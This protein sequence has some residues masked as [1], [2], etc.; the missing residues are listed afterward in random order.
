MSIYQ[1]VNFRGFNMSCLENNA[2]RE[3]INKRN[4]RLYLMLKIEHFKVVDM[5]A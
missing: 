2:E 4:Q 5:S 1:N 3:K